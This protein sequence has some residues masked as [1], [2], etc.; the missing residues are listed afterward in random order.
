M[1][2][3]RYYYYLITSQDKPLYVG[4]GT[5]S[6]CFA[7]LQRPEFKHVKELNIEVFYQDDEY[8]ALSKE[9]KLIR[10]I[11]IKPN[12]PLINK[13]IPSLPMF[14][15]NDTN[16]LDIITEQNEVFREQENMV[17]YHLKDFTKTL[18]YS[19]GVAADGDYLCYTIIN[20]LKRSIKRL[21]PLKPNAEDLTE[22]LEAQKVK[23]GNLL[24][25]ARSYRGD[26]HLEVSENYTS[27]RVGCGNTYTKK[28]DRSRVAPKSWAAYHTAFS[29]RRDIC[30]E[31]LLSV[32]QILRA[33][34]N[35]KLPIGLAANSTSPVGI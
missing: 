10:E 12:G 5:A 18:N 26:F 32:F 31:D 11:G 21:A 15:S 13:V 19:R 25:V 14:I 3:R 29:K 33:G 28:W 27:V 22:L 35:K 34:F 9:A 6:R 17:E 24:Y 1:E 7:H 20:T 23:F 8:A 2:N 16:I 4:K 30:T